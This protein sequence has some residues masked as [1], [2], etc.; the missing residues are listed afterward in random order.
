MITKFK[1]FEHSKISF[2]EGDLVRFKEP[3]E[4]ADIDVVFIVK[5]TDI[6]KFGNE[7]NLYIYDKYL[8]YMSNQINTLVG[9]GWID[10]DKLEKLS[11]EEITAMKYNL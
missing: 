7:S 5:S 3:N 1:L 6:S 4:Y 11:D 10:N 8:K 9:T 2:E